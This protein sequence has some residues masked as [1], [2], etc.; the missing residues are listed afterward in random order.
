M[1]TSLKF[2]IITALKQLIEE[3]KEDKFDCSESAASQVT[4][5]LNSLRNDERFSK[6]QACEYLGISRSTFDCYVKRGN[7]PKGR[8]QQ[9]FK[10]LYWYKSDLTT[11]KLNELD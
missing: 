10:E 9:G 5:L 7:I 2:V 3:I 8:K 11:T 1:D 4:D 6:S